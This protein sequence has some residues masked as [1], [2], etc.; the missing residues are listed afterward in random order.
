MDVHLKKATIEDCEKIHKIQIT[1]YKPLLDK[2][3]DFEFN[4]GAETYECFRNRFNNAAIN[5]YI[6]EASDTFIGYFRVFLTGENICRFSALF[7]LPKYQG[8]GYAQQAMKQVEKLYPNITKWTLSTIKQ[9]Q[10]L[11]HLYEKMGYTAISEEAVKD[12][13]DLIN[14]EKVVRN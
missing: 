7:I 3:Q 11:C 2:Y 4:P 13:M 10:K 12:G 1:A 5:H 14:Y 9:E 6:I 8:K